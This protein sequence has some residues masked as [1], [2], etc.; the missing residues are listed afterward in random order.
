[1]DAG[2]ALGSRYYLVER[3]GSGSM[4]EV[5][6]AVDHTTSKEFAAKLL[7][8]EYAG[9]PEI[10]VRFLR[11]MQ[12][13]VG[14]CHENLVEVREL[15]AEGGGVLAIVMELVRGGTL[16]DH[17]A[18]R[19]TLPPREAAE[20]TIAVLRALA[21]VHAL[22]GEV[23]HRDV[24]PENVLLD[25]DGRPKLTDFGI[26]RLVAEKKAASSGRLG[27]AEYMAPEVIEG[28]AAL[29]PCDVYGTG[30]QLYELLAGRTPFAGG[31]EHAVAYRH[32]NALPP[33]VRGLSA[34]LAAVL[35]GMLLK[36]PSE[37]PTAEAAADA[38]TR[39]LPELAG[40]PAL[41]AQAHPATYATTAGGTAASGGGASGT[42][43]T[44]VK[45]A[46]Q[47]RVQGPVGG[48]VVRLSPADDQ[49]E[50]AASPGTKIVDRPVVQPATIT[51]TVLSRE[52]AAKRDKVLVVAGVLAAVVI[53]GVAVALVAGRGSGGGERAKP[54]EQ[55]GPVKATMPGRPLPTGLTVSRVAVYD[56]D[57]GRLTTTVTW[58]AGETP[59]AGPFFEAV[60]DPGCTVTWEP[61]PGKPTLDATPGVTSPCS[62]QIS[63]G[64]LRAGGQATATYA[65]SFD[66]GDAEPLVA[67]ETFLT[68]AA[69]QTAAA[70]DGLERS[71]VFPAQRLVDV[72]VDV[73]SIV[74][75]GDRMPIRVLPIWA[76]TRDPDSLNVLFDTTTAGDPPQVLA[77]LG[78]IANV[79]LAPGGCHDAIGVLKNRYPWA[80][81]QADDCAIT[82]TV[83]NIEADSGSFSILV[84]P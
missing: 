53:A 82:A 19:G 68:A 42:G 79:K 73:P 75:A 54:R 5:W 30:V 24:K 11:E 3:L 71:A 37:R 67:A 64:A 25:G 77:R 50:Q 66:P 57:E 44:V 26:A 80:S 9:D 34:R 72:Y 20:I 29:P 48:D 4:G 33:P 39:L 10:V 51:P 16:R 81:E 18:G 23:V 74:H 76:G 21:Y 2:R 35:D 69:E 55:V 12:I 36:E 49:G 78:G 38:L 7:R 28:K 1:M 65:V 61:G 40:V 47:E 70:L 46:R 43:G 31:N 63:V 83:G 15:V 13:L 60:P 32:G 52:P 8:Q 41:P 84:R 27:T 45:D 62:Y 6:L 59:L 58:E 17:L 22:P 14:L 56:A